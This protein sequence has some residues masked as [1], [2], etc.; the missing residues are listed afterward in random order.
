VQ[1]IGIDD[2][3]SLKLFAGFIKNGEKHP[4]HDRKKNAY[5]SMSSPIDPSIIE[6]RKRA[7]EASYQRQLDLA[8]KPGYDPQLTVKLK[9]DLDWLNE[10]KPEADNFEN[11]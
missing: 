1:G 11:H 6:A 8:G 7:I 5:C 10:Q 3:F 9:E 2:Y 4:V